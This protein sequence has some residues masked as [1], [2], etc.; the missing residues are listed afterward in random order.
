M[1]Q[2]FRGL[3][4]FTLIL[5]ALPHAWAQQKA[6]PAPAKH[7]ADPD[8]VTLNF[9]N[10]DLEA[11]V[12]AFGQFLHKD[13]LVDPRVKGTISISSEHPVTRAEAYRLL[14]AALRFQGFTIVEA[15]GISKVLPEAD[16]KF[17]GGPTEI[18]RD[19]SSRSDGIR[20]DQIVTQVFHLNYDSA[21]NMVNVLRPRTRTTTRSSSPTMRRTCDAS[22]R[23][24]PRRIRP[25][26]QN[27]TWSSCSMPWRAI[28]PRWC[29]A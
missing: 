14:L 15:G 26:R 8:T 28:S 5:C 29:S 21:S 6:P 20:G 16:A 17:A 19:N 1:A 24:S 11:A 13:F 22:R 7:A 9:V 2:A 10:A 4:A 23:S 27:R 18:T 12:H 25:R 3:F